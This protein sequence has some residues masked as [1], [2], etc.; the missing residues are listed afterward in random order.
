MPGATVGDGYGSRTVPGGFPRRAFELMEQL[1]K[2]HGG[3]GRPARGHTSNE[4]R[5]LGCSQELLAVARDGRI[6]LGFVCGVVHRESIFTG[7]QRSLGF[8]C[9]SS[10]D[11]TEHVGKVARCSSGVRAVGRSRRFHRGHPHWSRR[12]GQPDRRFLAQLVRT[13]AMLDALPC[14]VR[15]FGAS[16]TVQDRCTG[17]W[18]VMGLRNPSD[19]VPELVGGSFHP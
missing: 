4:S 17:T 2:W 6:P 9:A 7:L 11:V 15:T 16:R 13:V 10:H 5:V 14:M 19:V 18:T 8:L 1:V 3:T 12:T